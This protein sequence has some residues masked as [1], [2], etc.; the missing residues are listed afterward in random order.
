M[1]TSTINWFSLFVLPYIRCTVSIDI[2]TLKSLIA[3]VNQ[4]NLVVLK[5]DCRSIKFSGY[6]TENQPNGHPT[7][8][9]Y[10]LQFLDD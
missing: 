1:L 6:A 7:H 5:C 9:I 4:I 2:I 3:T 8:I 10:S